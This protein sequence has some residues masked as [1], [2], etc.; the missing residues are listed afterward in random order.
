MKGSHWLA[1]SAVTGLILLGAGAGCSWFQHEE[2]P[3]G[4]EHP[5]EHVEHPG[6]TH[7]AEH[8]TE[9][10]EHPTEGAEHPTE[11][12]EHPTSVAPVGLGLP[13]V[14]ALHAGV[15]VMAEHPE[16]PATGAKKAEAAKAEGATHKE[17]SDHKEGAAVKPKPKELTKDDVGKSIE[18]YIE[19]DTKL[20]GDY[21]LVYDPV[22]KGALVLTLDKVHKDRLSITD[23]KNR[24]AFACSD[25]KTPKGKV[26]DLDF[27]MKQDA[28]GKLQVTRIMVHKEAGKPRYTW[29]KEDGVWVRKPAK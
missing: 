7:E 29:H 1:V 14:A 2:H 19:H 24:I 21:F 18:A 27:W 16:H 25:F 28:A 13:Q 4:E 8:P 12:E 26:Y 6:S 5:G 9:G 3:T 23:R 15:L 17:G 22:D 11:G 10:E 20:K